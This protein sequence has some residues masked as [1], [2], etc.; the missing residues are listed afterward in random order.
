MGYKT[1]LAVSVSITAAML[2]LW[3]L[4]MFDRCWCFSGAE[5]RRSGSFPWC[6]R[7]ARQQ[8]QEQIHQHPPL[9]VTGSK[10]SWVTLSVQKHYQHL[11]FHVVRGGNCQSRRQVSF[12]VRF[13]PSELPTWCRLFKF[14][15]TFPPDDFS[16]VKLMSMHNDEG[17]DYINANYIP[18]SVTSAPG[19]QS[20]LDPDD[21]CWCR[22]QTPDW[23]SLI[24]ITFPAT[25]PF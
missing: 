21:T 23:I 18:V 6:S 9:W 15:S 5:E 2:T 25:D 20:H 11:M 24:L 22:S 8:A 10:A 4:Q 3:I 17:S 12:W 19:S 13:S 14:L 7:P 16:R 1:V